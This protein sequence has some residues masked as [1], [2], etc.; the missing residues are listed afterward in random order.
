MRGDDSVGEGAKQVRRGKWLIYNGALSQDTPGRGAVSPAAGAIG[1]QSAASPGRSSFNG[2]QAPT[3]QDFFRW[4]HVE[5]RPAVPSPAMRV[6][7]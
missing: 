3:P 7:Y 4:T 5:R 2:R 6:F 1:A